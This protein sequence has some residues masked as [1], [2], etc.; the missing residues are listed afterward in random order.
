MARININLGTPPSGLDG[1]PVRTAFE[2]TN[3]M[4]TELYRGNDAI[5]KSGWGAA[6]PVIQPNGTNAND[7]RGNFVAQFNEGGQGLPV[8]EGVATDYFFVKTNDNGA[9]Y[10]TQEAA[11]FVN[12]GAS[13][14]RQRTPSGGW[15]PW[16]RVLEQGSFGLG[17]ENFFSGNLDTLPATAP[18]GLTQYKCTSATTGTLPPGF[19]NNAPFDGGTVIVSKYSSDWCRVWLTGGTGGAGGSL[20]GTFVRLTVAGSQGPW[21]LELNSTNALNPVDNANG[22]VGVMD[23]RTIGNWRVSRFLNG[24]VSMSAPGG[25]VSV[26]ANSLASSSFTVPVSMPDW[27]K[28]SVSVNIGAASD[29]SHFGVIEQYMDSSTAGHFII[30]NGATAQNFGLVRIRVTGYWK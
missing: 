7:L 6:T 2:K 29:N 16:K 20:G 26:A 9:G 14:K 28:C 4:F 27:G 25:A 23:D 17:G 5:N 10:C 15:S 1:D 3:T 30:R 19:I 22:R 18:I 13:F 12:P 21:L 11:S 8:F 24:F